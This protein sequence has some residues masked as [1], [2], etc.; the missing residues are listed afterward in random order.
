[1]P[2]SSVRLTLVIASLVCLLAISVSPTLLAVEP[3]KFEQDLLLERRSIAQ[4]QLEIDTDFA[5][6]TGGGRF[7]RTKRTIW[8]DEDKRRSDELREHIDEKG[9]TEVPPYRV[10]YIETPE[11]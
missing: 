1:M 10:V 7:T 8:Q 3:T 9:M 4:L 5:H 6:H 11:Y 2:I